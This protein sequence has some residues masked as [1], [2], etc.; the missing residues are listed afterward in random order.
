MRKEHTKINGFVE[1]A[2]KG[3][4]TVEFTKIDTDELR[5]MPSTLNPEL[6]DNN[7]PES[8]EQKEE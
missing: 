5:V 3:V 8:L 6:P 2:K 4:V 7:V 1:A